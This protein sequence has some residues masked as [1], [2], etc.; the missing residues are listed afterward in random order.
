MIETLKVSSRGQIVIPE[1]I[2]EELLIEEGTTLV[3]IKEGERII[4]ERESEF[5]KEIKENEERRAW[6][7]L[8]EKA[9]AK[10]WDNPKDDAAWNKY[11]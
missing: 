6:I 11:M 2:R 9:F 10:I 7:A 1:R 3:L 8:G 4:L 5:L